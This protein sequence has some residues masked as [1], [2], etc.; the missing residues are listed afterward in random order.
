MTIR[1]DPPDPVRGEP[2]LPPDL[3]KREPK[4]DPATGGAL[5]AIAADGN[6]G[7]RDANACIDIYSE[8][9]RQLSA[10]P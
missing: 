10:V 8:V 4:L 7:I 2:A 5:Y 9:R 1:P 6:A 3:V